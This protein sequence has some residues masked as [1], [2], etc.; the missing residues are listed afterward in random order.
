MILAIDQG[1]TGTTCLLFDR[2]GRI[3]GRAYSEF[4]QHFPQP[5]WVEHDAAEIWEVTRRVAAEAI[6]AA[7]IEGGELDGIGIAN[8][9]ETV[10]AWDPASGE[11][12]HRALVWQDR[13][14][15]GRCEELRAAGHEPLVRERTGLVLDPYFSGHQDRVAGAQ[16][17][18][19]RSGRSSARS[20]PGS[21]SSSP[22]ATPPTTPT[23]RGRCS[24]T[25][26]GGA[27]TRSSARCSGSTRR[28]C[29]SRCP[30]PASTG[31]RPSSAAR[32]PWRG[33]PATSRPRSSAR[34]AS[35]RAAPRTPTGPAASSSSTPANV[36]PTPSPGLLTTLACDDRR[37]GRLRA[38]GLDLRHRRRGA[39]AAR[40]ARRDRGGGR[41]GGAGGLARGQRRRLLRP[42][43][44]RARLAPLGP[45]CA[46][47][48]RRPHAGQRP[49][50]SGAGGAGGDRL[51]D[52][53]RGPR[54]GGGRRRTA[55]GAQGGRRRGRK[56]L[57][58]A[59][60]GRRPRRRGRRPRGCRDDRARR[61]LP[62]RNRDRRLEPRAGGGDVARGRP[63]RAGDGRGRAS[64]AARRA[65]TGPSSARVAGP[66]PTQPGRNRRSS[67]G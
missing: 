27:G 16:R 36:R 10:V 37:A 11:P 64:L 45:L 33:S 65:G 7:G 59:V 20:T 26:T 62:G 51:P 19:R 22:A 53:R 12:L 58:D 41:D 60:P 3:A 15:A 18:G 17:R 13:R 55:R 56:R 46:R 61:R 44:D 43:P 29:R 9:R 5:G 32:S 42:R 57:A 24:S 1:T 48:D 6:A 28:G 31:R 4:E 2:E 35:S 52:R 25:S 21:S 39:V 63:L 47:D 50:P 34:P 40:R 38:G 54:P 8:Q 14:T 23:P 30:P 67:R 49:S 66:T